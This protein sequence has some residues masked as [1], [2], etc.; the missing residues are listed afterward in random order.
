MIKLVV[1]AGEVLVFLLILVATGPLTVEGAVTSIC[2]ITPLGEYAMPRI[3]WDILVHSG[4]FRDV[5]TSR[6]NRIC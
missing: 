5:M 2:S 4:I 1:G 6:A 3:F